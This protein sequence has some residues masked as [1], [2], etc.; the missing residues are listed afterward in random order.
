MIKKIVMMSHARSGTSR[1]SQ[2]FKIH[3][4]NLTPVN[5]EILHPNNISASRFIDNNLSNFSNSNLIDYSSE[6]V[7]NPDFKIQKPLE[8]INL[9]S[10]C[11][12]NLGYKYIFFKISPIMLKNDIFYFLNSLCNVKFFYFT[13]NILDT[14]ISYKKAQYLNTW[15]SKDTSNVKITIN[16]RDFL[17]YHYKYVD[18]I[19]KT[20]EVISS[21]KR[22]DM[23]TYEQFFNSGINEFDNFK[24]YFS[25]YINESDIFNTSI[26]NQRKKKFNLNRQDNNIN[27]ENKISNADDIKKLIKENDLVL[28]CID[29]FK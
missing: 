21:N 14:Y 2:L 24:N 3:C 20:S 11:A 5:Q 29:L 12:E 22:V 7:K 17:N 23:Y 19:T 28:N 13:R 18:W 1:L 4:K 26:I 15:S 6:L 9:L 10:E 25:S 8:F 16:E 27:W